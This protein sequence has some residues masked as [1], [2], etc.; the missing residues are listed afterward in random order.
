[1]T[2]ECTTLHHWRNVKIGEPKPCGIINVCFTVRERV[3][4]FAYTWPRHVK[5][6]SGMPGVSNAYSLVVRLKCDSGL[7]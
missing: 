5:S 4:S 1:M 6:A 2:I 3:G 7:Q